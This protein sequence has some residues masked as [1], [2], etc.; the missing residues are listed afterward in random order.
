[1]GNEVEY[2]SWAYVL[3]PM[4]YSP[5]VFPFCNVTTYYD[6]EYL[7]NR[8]C[9]NKSPKNISLHWLQL[10]G[11]FSYRVRI[12]NLVQNV[13]FRIS[14]TSIYF[15]GNMFWSKISRAKT[16]IFIII[17]AMNVCITIYKLLFLKGLLW[18]L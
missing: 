9:L 4:K 18:I 3:L 5:Y 13:I 11:I 16:T 6:L 12:Y 15:N 1:M 2:T 8:A 10:M 7:Q 17:T 14:T